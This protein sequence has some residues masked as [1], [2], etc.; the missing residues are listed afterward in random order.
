[1]QI[2]I[3]KST[4][5]R[6]CRHDLCKKNPNLISDD[7]KIKKEVICAAV[8]I[9]SSSGRSTAYYCRECIDHLYNDIK[10]ILNP[11]LWILH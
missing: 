11:N 5:R 6:I 1:M 4:G 2:K 8:T 7:G 9:T 3:E 10:K